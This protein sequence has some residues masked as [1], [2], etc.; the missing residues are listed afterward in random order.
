MAR[1]PV[2]KVGDPVK[3]TKGR[4]PKKGHVL[5]AKRGGPLLVSVGE[6]GRRTKLA[7]VDVEPIPV[8]AHESLSNCKRTASNFAVNDPVRVIWYS[9]G[10]WFGLVQSVDV[11]TNT[12]KVKWEFFGPVCRCDTFGP[13]QIEPAKP[14]DVVRDCGQPV[15]QC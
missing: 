6:A 12:V 5:E 4:I 11:A 7:Q 14:T 3:I 13:C 9:G 2:F 15:N 10:P 1:A 8:I